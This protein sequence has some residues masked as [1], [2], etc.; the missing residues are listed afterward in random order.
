MIETGLAADDLGKTILAACFITDIGTAL[1]L[2]L[3]FADFNPLPNAFIVATGVALFILP[4]TLRWFLASV[5][6]RVSGIGS[7]SAASS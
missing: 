6:G 4:R 5:S 7:A 3:L 2:G 1:A